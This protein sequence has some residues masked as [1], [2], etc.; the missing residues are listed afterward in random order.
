M[1]QFFITL[2]L[3]NQAIT[4]NPRVETRPQWLTRQPYWLKASVVRMAVTGNE[5]SQPFHTTKSKRF[6]GSKAALVMILLSMEIARRKTLESA[7]GATTEP[8]PVIGGN[9]CNAIGELEGET[10]VVM[11]KGAIASLADVFPPAWRRG[12]AYIAR[13]V[14]DSRP[15]NSACILIGTTRIKNTKHLF[16]RARPE[17][18]IQASVEVT[19][20]GL[21]CDLAKIE[22]IF[23]AF[24]KARGGKGG[25]NY[26][27]SEEDFDHESDAETSGPDGIIGREWIY[28]KIRASFDAGRTRGA[29][30]KPGGDYICLIAPPGVG[31]STIC[32][33]YS[34]RYNLP[35]IFIRRGQTSTSGFLCQLHKQVSQRIAKLKFQP[36][37]EGS[38]SGPEY[39]TKLLEA[40]DAALKEDDRYL[41]IVIDALDE[42]P[43]EVLELLPRW[44][45]KRVSILT[46]FRGSKEESSPLFRKVENLES[47]VLKPDSD[48]N[49]A[50]VD[51]YLAEAALLPQVSDYARRK[52]KTVDQVIRLLRD[53][54]E[55]N[56]MY[57][58]YVLRDLAEKAQFYE[59][60]EQ[61]PKGLEGYYDLHIRVIRD[62]SGTT[63]DWN[64]IKI[65][66]LTVL[67]SCGRPQSIEWI[68]RFAS[69]DPKHGLRQISIL[70][71]LE[72]I[73]QFLIDQQEKIKNDRVVTTYRIYHTDFRDFLNCRADLC[74]DFG[75]Q[76]KIRK[77]IAALQMGRHKKGGAK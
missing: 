53:R 73:S 24:K 8:E 34:Q 20:N 60:M 61:L 19:L 14:P 39:A 67:A 75:I 54:S 72:E 76:E 4:D 25:E 9:L 62:K 23:N 27:H 16:I 47:F 5:R 40:A 68:Q 55:F 74:D 44:L 35:A 69:V 45:P 59:T 12:D 66:I 21:P 49:K 52:K 50:D 29:P 71:F 15:T 10:E 18:D 1:T 32:R 58:Y 38:L 22:E 70:R 26:E 30:L 7:T 46:T 37:S 42:A 48:E 3:S 43:S 13:L 57:L 6:S 31:K 77:H 64:H 51:Q 65:P 36:P 17:G 56:F 41:E 63:Q 33:G 28:T 2:D 11:E